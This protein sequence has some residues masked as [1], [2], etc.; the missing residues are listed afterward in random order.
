VVVVTVNALSFASGGKIIPVCGLAALWEKSKELI[1]NYKFDL[2]ACMLNA[3]SGQA[4]VSIFNKAGSVLPSFNSVCL[5]FSELCT[6]TNQHLNNQKVLMVGNGAKG[7]ALPSRELIFNQALAAIEPDAP[8]VARVAHKL[9]LSGVTPQQKIIP[10]YIK[11][12]FTTSEP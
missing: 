11:P 8:S 9:F 4:F 1:S 2:I 3:Y 10:N 12:G 5:T 6:L 7:F